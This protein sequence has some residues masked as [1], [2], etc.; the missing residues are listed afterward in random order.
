MTDCS[1]TTLRGHSSRV[2]T[3][4]AAD[5]PFAAQGSAPFSAQGSAPPLAATSSPVGAADVSPGTAPSG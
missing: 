5:P 1:S 2:V 4:R 3:M